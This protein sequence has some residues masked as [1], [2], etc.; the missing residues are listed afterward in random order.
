MIDGDADLPVELQHPRFTA[1]PLTAD[2]AALDYAA[3][4]AS[5]DVIRAHSDGRW[6]LEGF[7]L[8]DDLELVAQHQA[9]HASRRAFTFVLLAPSRAEALG[10]VYLNPLLDYLHRAGAATKLLDRVPGSSAMVSFWIRQDLLDTGLPEA[11]AEAVDEWL[12]TAWPVAMHLF[13]V[14]PGEASSVRALDRLELPQ[15]RLELVDEERPFLW[16]G[17]VRGPLNDAAS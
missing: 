12:L 13:R 4:M 6:P 17:A 15:I 9:D 3:Y 2:V 5:P 16:Y 7:T 14:L 10:C 8:S 1:T 11:V